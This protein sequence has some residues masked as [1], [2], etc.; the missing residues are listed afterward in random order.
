[1]LGYTLWHYI[2][3]CYQTFTDMC[4]ADGRF[5]QGTYLRLS[6]LVYILL[7]NPGPNKNS[8]SVSS[9]YQ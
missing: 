1:M 9:Y 5:A 7:G 2:L 8:A 3:Y 6:Y 4:L